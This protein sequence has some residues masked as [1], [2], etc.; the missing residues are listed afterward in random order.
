MRS[1]VL[2]L[3]LVACTPDPGKGGG[4]GVDSGGDADTDADTDTD[5]GTDTDGETADA[6]GD[7]FIRWDL[8]DDPTQADCDDND[9]S[10]TPATERH[11]PAG[12]FRMGDDQGEDDRRPARQV[13]LS[14]YCIDVYEVTNA[15]FVAFLESRAAVGQPNQDD[16]G[17][18]LFDFE[19]DDDTVPERI[20]DDGDGTYSIEPGYEQHPV[21]E[22]WHWS[23]MAYCDDQAKTLPT[24]AQWEKAARGPD[25]WGYPWGE[26]APDCA[27]G[28]LRPGPEGVGPDGQGVDPCVDDTTP[29]GSYPGSEGAYG[30]LDMAGNVA[31]WVY[32]WY[33]VDGYQ[34]SGNVDPTGPESGWSDNLPGGGGPARVTRGGSFATADI[35]LHN[36]YRYIEP[37]EG[38]SNGVGFRCVRIL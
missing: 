24:E 33:R 9:P 25:D 3:A 6:D 17:N 16:E 32:D 11:V 7:G 28:N 38:T 2:S 35:A 21:T 29:V 30:T 4:G 10:V 37:A 36:A 27:L 12:T 14:D 18:P 26:D 15:E 19:D 34:T 5:G 1:F 22:V 23:G 8:T 13:E 20:I 31:E